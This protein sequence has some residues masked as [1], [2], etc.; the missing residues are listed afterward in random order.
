MEQLLKAVYAIASFVLGLVALIFVAAIALLIVGQW[1]SFLIWCL[2]LTL[3]VAVVLIAA[4]LLNVQPGRKAGMI[5]AASTATSFYWAMFVL[6]PNLSRLPNWFLFLLAMPLDPEGV[7]YDGR[8]HV[9]PG[10]DMAGLRGIIVIVSIAGLLCLFG[11]IAESIREF[12]NRISDPTRAPET[13]D[14]T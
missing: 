8:G 13:N 14:A 11:L 2:P 10:L 1:A 3:S 9:E 7:A 4:K 6:E 5:V 12:R